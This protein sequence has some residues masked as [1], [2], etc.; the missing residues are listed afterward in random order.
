M[1][2][3]IEKQFKSVLVIDIGGDEVLKEAKTEEQLTEHLFYRLLDDINK[4]NS[5]PDKILKYIDEILF[6]S[7]Q[8][9]TL[10]FYY[11]DLIRQVIPE[12]RDKK[13]FKAIAHLLADGKYLY[14]TDEDRIQSIVQESEIVIV[15]SFISAISTLIYLNTDKL[16]GYRKTGNNAEARWEEISD[17]NKYVLVIAAL[18]FLNRSEDEFI[19]ASR[20]TM[21][22]YARKVKFKNKFWGRN[23]FR[24]CFL[25]EDEKYDQFI[26]ELQIAAGPLYRVDCKKDSF[27]LKGIKGNLLIT[28]V[29]IMSEIKR[30]ELFNTIVMPEYNDRLIIILDRTPEEL[31]GF[32][33]IIDDTIFPDDL[34]PELSPFE[35]VFMRTRPVINAIVQSFNNTLQF[36][37]N[38]VTDKKEKEKLLRKQEQFRNMGDRFNPATVNFWY[39]ND[40]GPAIK[41]A[42]AYGYYHNIIK[43]KFYDAYKVKVIRF[44]IRH[45][46]E[47][48]EWE[49][50]KDNEVL[51]KLSYARSSGLKYIIYLFK[52][53]S[54]KAI[55]ASELRKV[56]HQWNKESIVS[57]TDATDAKKILQDLIYLFD[58]QC[59][60]LSQLRECVIISSKDPGCYYE[61]KK[62]IVLEVTDREVPPP[63]N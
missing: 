45:D 14:T 2:F 60:E 59:P 40:I 61:P 31:V 39:A 34:F 7:I 63:C 32:P 13:E 25:A 9:E 8:D 49:I 35:I 28:S 5:L 55:S 44:Q 54:A 11:Y 10:T 27:E 43:K 23:R 1:I 6:T 48:Q 15:E 56:I 42:E 16:T 12:L 53:Y 30:K 29:E 46:Y 38:T 41:Y 50:I 4:L 33:A 19:A 21:S 26:N 24:F 17:I 22:E 37:N 20:M 18:Y 51:R 62:N 57:T 36:I 58:K 52:H 3:K 47:K